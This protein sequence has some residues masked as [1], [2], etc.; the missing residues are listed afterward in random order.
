MF[1]CTKGS[2]CRVLRMHK[3]PSK[4]LGQNMTIHHPTLLT[5]STQCISEV[6]KTNFPGIMVIY[7]QTQSLSSNISPFSML[8]IVLRQMGLLKAHP[9]SGLVESI[10]YWPNS[11]ANDNFIQ[12]FAILTTS[13]HYELLNRNWHLENECSAGQK[14][15]HFT[16]ALKRGV[17]THRLACFSLHK[18]QTTIGV[19]VAN[20]CYTQE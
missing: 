16:R 5:K 8:Q 3:K 19:R 11:M 18:Q 4:A 17:L 14:H 2:L 10:I 20:K 12:K 6:L 9:Y 15:Q 13:A 7:S 1:W